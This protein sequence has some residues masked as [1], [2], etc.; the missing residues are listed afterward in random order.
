MGRQKDRGGRQGE[1]AD[2][3]GKINLKG[4]A[5]LAKVTRLT[6]AELHQTCDPVLNHDAS[7]VD[8]GEGLRLLILPVATKLFGV[9]GDGYDPG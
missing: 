4:N 1:V 8:L 3:S 5:S 6:D 2:R 7:P 9:L